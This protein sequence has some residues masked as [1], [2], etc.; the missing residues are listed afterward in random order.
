MDSVARLLPHLP[1]LAAFADTGQVTAASDVLGVPQPQVSRSLA[2]AEAIT[3]IGLRHREGRTVT[4]TRAARELGDA[5]NTA[6]RLLGDALAG[7]D[8]ALRGRISIAFQHSLGEALVPSYIRD[9]THAYPA[10]EF[11]LTQ[12]SRAEC[13]AALDAGRADVAFIAVVPDALAHASKQVAVEELVLAV[14]R[15]HHLVGRDDVTSGDLASEHLIALRHG[16]GLRSTIDALLDR[17]GVSPRVAFEGQE[18]STVLGLVGAGLGVAIVPR[19]T[20]A[21]DVVLL[22]FRH[23]DASRPILLVTARHRAVGLAPQMFVDLVHRQLHDA[24]L[25]EHDM[26]SSTSDSGGSNGSSGGNNIGGTNA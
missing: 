25:G 14:P 26:S 20:Y 6:L 4:P 19:R 11:A 24:G 23:R 8:S 16:L 7:L 10:V 12:G 18:I 2:A 21:H 9:F 17:W 3:G 13:L 5:A 22:P 1:V 15:T